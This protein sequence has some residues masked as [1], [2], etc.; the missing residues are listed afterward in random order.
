M[1]DP[2]S[3]KVFLV[4]DVSTGK[5]ALRLRESEHTFVPESTFT[6]G[7]GLDIVNYPSLGATLQL[8]DM[9]GQEAFRPA[10]N[11]IYRNTRAFMICVDVSA[12]EN[13]KILKQYVK[14][15]IR[16]CKSVQNSDPIFILVGT[17]A[18]K[19][20]D[21]RALKVSKGEIEAIAK[22]NK[23]MYFETSAKDDLGVA[24]LFTY[25]VQ[26]LIN[27]RLNRENKGSFFS[28]CPVPTLHSM[29]EVGTPSIA[30][31][32]GVGLVVG[33]IVGLVTLNPAAA[34]I[35]GFFA[36]A[37]TLLISTFVGSLI[38]NKP[39]TVSFFRSFKMCTNEDDLDDNTPSD[40][41]SSSPTSAH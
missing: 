4:G 32:V 38:K 3:F 18:D 33:G 23:M 22:N 15:W 6:I 28:R 2:I 25:T 19:N 26:T 40:S 39:P 9:A 24:E 36:A 1:A 27:N 16:E 35:A 17:K 31:S 5:S 41:I 11:S 12:I 8:L 37:A 30:L 13:S 34:A 29:L 7:I 10:T 21:V 20:L 14:K